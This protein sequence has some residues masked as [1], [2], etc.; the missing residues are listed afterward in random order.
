MS[1][2]KL[3]TTNALKHS[4]IT[5]INTKPIYKKPYRLPEASREDVN[6][7]INKMLNDGVIKPSHSPWNFPLLIVPKKVMDLKKK[8]AYSYR[9]S[10]S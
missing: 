1:G 2:D 9:F 7:E 5:P 4:I 3:T 10:P 6:L 8:M